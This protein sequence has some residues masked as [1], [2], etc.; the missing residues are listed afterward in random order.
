MRFAA[1]TGVMARRFT[2]RDIGDEK[3][4]P[5]NEPCTVLAVRMLSASRSLIRGRRTAGRR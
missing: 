4:A 3:R 5:A 1:L 2:D